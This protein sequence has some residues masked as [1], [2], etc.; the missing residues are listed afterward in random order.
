MS[1][2]AKPLSRRALLQMALCGAGSLALRSLATGIPMHF[3]RCPEAAAAPS[4]A[5]CAA[6]QFLVLSSSASG[7]PLNANVPGTFENPALF[8]S[9]DPSMAPTPVVLGGTTYH[10]A[11][12]WASFVNLNRTCFFHNRTTINGHNSAP[13]V[14]RMLNSLPHQEMLISAYASQLAPCLG[15]LQASPIGLGVQGSGEAL[16]AAGRPLAAISP[17]SLTNTLGSP[18]GPLGDLQGLRNAT[19]DKMQAYLKTQS[20]PWGQRFIDNYTISLA[21]ARNL[22]TNLLSALSQIRDNGLSAQLTAA[23]VLMKMKVAPAFTIHAPF[24][25]DNHFDVGVRGESAQLISS[26]GA[27]NTFQTNLG[28]LAD[29]VTLATWNVFGRTLGTSS[30][31]GLNY[32]RNHNLNHHVM[33]LSGK[34]VKGSVVGGIVPVGG[35]FGASDIDSASG[36]GVMGGDV[37]ALKTLYS[38]GSTLGMALG[39]DEAY[40]RSLIPVAPPI[41]A[42]L[43]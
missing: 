43:S 26:L 7:D 20:T 29:S 37:P 21:Q 28:S 22:S 38:A 31:S 19:L 40:V 36:Q 13:S 35:D 4:P 25:G 27:L 3:L 12:P 16:Y 30:N 33:V 11:A 24:G 18:T 23:T 5:V 6:P 32:G 14:W 15:T 1:H 41:K 34:H 9:A 39:L 17:T 10:T 42:A 2:P 8:H